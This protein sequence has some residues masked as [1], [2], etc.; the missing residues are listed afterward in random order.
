MALC[1]SGNWKWRYLSNLPA[2]HQC[3]C[4]EFININIGLFFIDINIGPIFH[5][6]QLCL[7]HTNK[8]TNHS[9]LMALSN[10]SAS[11]TRIGDFALPFH[12]KFLIN[13]N[14]CPVS[15]LVEIW[16]FLIACAVDSKTQTIMLIIRGECVQ[17]RNE[18][19]LH[20]V[21]KHC[22]IMPHS[23]IHTHPT[24]TLISTNSKP[25]LPGR[26]LLSN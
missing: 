2:V 15:L 5:Q 19:I 24:H 7:Y 14:S 6:H 3:C 11:I 10:L 12:L 17:H 4:R 25:T 16:L 26:Q 22:L 23:P 20:K 8:F 21:R 1:C 9:I 18:Q 13:T